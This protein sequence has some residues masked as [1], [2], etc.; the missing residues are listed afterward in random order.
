MAHDHD[1]H[2]PS[3]AG[4]EHDLHDPVPPGEKP[5]F[6]Q[7]ELRDAAEEGP[8]GSHDDARRGP[9]EHVHRGHG[10]HDGHKPGHGEMGHDHHAMM[11]E[12]FK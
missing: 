5:G 8:H 9:V 11:V 7:E 4:H 6:K 1:H 12:D 10:G 2:R 3:Q